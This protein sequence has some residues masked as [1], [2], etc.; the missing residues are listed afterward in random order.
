MYT[1]LHLSK[2]TGDYE[3]TSP[4]VVTNDNEEYM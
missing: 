4:V 2:V 3:I 1:L